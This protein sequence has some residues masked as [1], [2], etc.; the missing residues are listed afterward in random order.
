M[1]A[2]RTA[3][4]KCVQ[5]HLRR[6]PFIPGVYGERPA[7]LPQGA[8]SDFATPSVL[9]NDARFHP[10]LWAAHLL[11]SQGAPWEAHEVL[12]ALW[13]VCGRSG[14]AADVVKACI[15]LCAYDVK[16]V[17]GVAS[18][19]RSHASGAFELARSL[20]DD[21]GAVFGPVSLVDLCDLSS[22][23]CKGAG[24]RVVGLPLVELQAH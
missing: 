2:A 11:L 7:P 15:K 4:A 18:G 8:L 5:Q 14:P 24:Q 17:Q 3:I 16:C 13:H 6:G 19:Q 23:L 20:I 22:H 12:E 21:C 10:S 9:T 1:H